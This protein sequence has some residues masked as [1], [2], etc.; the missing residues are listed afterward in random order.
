MLGKECPSVSEGPD[1]ECP[2]DSYFDHSTL[3]CARCPPDFCCA[4]NIRKACPPGTLANG[5]CPIG[6]FCTHVPHGASPCQEGFFQDL[7]GSI[8]CKIVPK[9]YQASPEKTA[10]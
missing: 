2:V 1:R 5:L 8:R 4:D 9:G 3:K 10:I 7:E 6:H